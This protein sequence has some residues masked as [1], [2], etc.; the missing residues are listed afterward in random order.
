M[1][2]DGPLVTAARTSLLLVLALTF[3]VVIA[4]RIEVFGVRGDLMLLVAVA[5]GLVAGPDR[6]AIVGFAAGLS[7]DLLLQTPMGLRALTYCLVAFVAGSLQD[8]VLRAAW[9][10]PVSTAAAASSLGVILYGVFGSVVG[11]DL[12]VLSLL[13]IALVV[14]VFNTIAAP[15][16]L[17]VVRWAIV[18]ARG[19]RPSVSGR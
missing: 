9:W 7:F 17:R 2:P 16:V 10:I 14:G 3:Q 19:L 5:A 12:L 4:S 6:G 18:P 11:E 1:I 13:R 8:A 15:A